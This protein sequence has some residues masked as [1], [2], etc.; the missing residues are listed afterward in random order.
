[1]AENDCPQCGHD[2][3][4]LLA[5]RFKGERG[6]CECGCEYPR[7]VGRR[8]H[9]RPAESAPRLET[10]PAKSAPLSEGLVAILPLDSAQPDIP[11]EI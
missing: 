5:G 2:H 10:Q 4:V 1:M 11:R 6:G 8:P 9:P 3:V 7:P